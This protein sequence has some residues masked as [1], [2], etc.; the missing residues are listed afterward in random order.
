MAA[1]GRM[2]T[3]QLQTPTEAESRLARESSRRLGPRHRF[4]ISSKRCGRSHGDGST[5][6]VR[7]R[8]ET[9][10]CTGDPG[11]SRSNC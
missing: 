5:Q 1:L 2:T 7:S 11:I 4:S 3:P 9:R 8:P 6:C 10:A